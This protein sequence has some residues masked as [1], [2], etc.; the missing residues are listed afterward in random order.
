MESVT[1]EQ[2]QAK[3]SELK[4]EFTSHKKRVAEI[5]NLMTKL[6]EEKEQHLQALLRAQGGY[7][8]LE[9]FINVKKDNEEQH[10]NTKH[11]QG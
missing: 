11:V 2:L 6:Q 7:K 10:G 3:Q 1:Q 8:A 4:A 5:D 9:S